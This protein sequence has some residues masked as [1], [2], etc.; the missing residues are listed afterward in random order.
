[1]GW[2]ESKYRP[3]SG[4]DWVKFGNG[5]DK[6]QSMRAQAANFC[7]ALEGREPLLITAE[8]AVAS[9]AVIQAPYA[10]MESSAWVPVDGATSSA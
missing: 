10:S 5:Y 7:A 4:A 8:D 1:M 2:K 3:R 6:I 9:V